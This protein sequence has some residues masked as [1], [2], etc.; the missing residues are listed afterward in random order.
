MHFM[1]RP[2]NT[3][4][5]SPPYSEPGTTCHEF[6]QSTNAEPNWPRRANE[7]FARFGRGGAIRTVVALGE[8]QVTSVPR[9][10][11]RSRSGGRHEAY[12]SPPRVAI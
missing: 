4:L 10:A 7:I 1:H 8:T 11:W 5:D 2:T 6:C 3:H 9:R 12:L